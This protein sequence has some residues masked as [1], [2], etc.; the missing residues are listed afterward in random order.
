VTA[1]ASAPEHLVEQLLDTLR[2]DTA[3]RSTCARW[4]RRTSASRRRRRCGGWRW[5]D[6]PPGSAPPAPGGVPPHRLTDIL[7]SSHAGRR[8]R[9]PGREG[10][11]PEEVRR[12]PRVLLRDLQPQGVRGPGHPGRVRAGQP[13]A[14]GRGRRRPRA[15]LPAAAGR[16]AQAA[17]R[18]ARRDPGRRRR[19]PPLVPDVRPARRRGAQRRQLAAAVHPGR[20]RPRV[21]H[22]RAE[23]RGDLQGHRASTPPSTTAASAGTTP[24][25]AIDWGIDEAAAVLSD[26]DRKHP[27]LSAAPQLFD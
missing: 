15:A 20:L 14:V 2:R 11:G 4:S 24:R 16:A 5:S 19:R 9:H 3:A 26:R 1:G 12:P 27:V 7:R 6:D 21:P 23:H 8:H 25:S 18:R 10:A 13:L 17:P 22:A